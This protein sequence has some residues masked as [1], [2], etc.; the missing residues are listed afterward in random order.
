M[1]RAGAL[2]RLVCLLA[3]SAAGAAGSGADRVGKTIYLRGLLG[4]GAPLEGVREEGVVTTGADAA[5][6]TIVVLDRLI[7]KFTGWLLKPRPDIS[8]PANFGFPEGFAGAVLEI[9]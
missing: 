8:P 9:K 6:V 4:S 2:A 5:C 1:R 7:G 3:G